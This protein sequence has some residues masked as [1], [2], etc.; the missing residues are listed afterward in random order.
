M[1]RNPTESYTTHLST[2]TWYAFD[3]DD[4]LH[5]F[6]NASTTASTAVFQTIHQETGVSIGALKTTYRDILARTAD[7]SAFT[8]GKTSL[9][10]RRDRFSRLLHRHVIPSSDEKVDSLVRIYQTRLKEALRLKPGAFQLLQTIKRLGKYVLVI[11]EGPQDSQE[12]TLNELGL[13]PYVD[14]LVTSNGMGVSK[15]DGLFPLVLRRFA[16]SA[17]DMLYMGD[18][19]SRD[20][21]PAR[22]VG[23]LAVLYDQS[24][25]SQLHDPLDLRVNSLTTLSLML[26]SP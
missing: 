18:N 3:L 2:K 11:T 1:D 7:V 13:L 17:Q 4:T 15:V 9:E 25:P 20:V 22:E 5:E 14:L 10:Y 8:D 19:E 23:I 21:L 6:R 12:W 16:I 26:E 24:G